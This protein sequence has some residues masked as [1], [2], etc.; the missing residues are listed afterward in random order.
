[1][2]QLRC[3]RC[4]GSM[5]VEVSTIP[6]MG[7]LGAQYVELVCRQCGERTSRLLPEQQARLQ[8]PAAEGATATAARPR[9]G[10]PPK[11][12]LVSVGGAK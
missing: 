10:R 6:E 11:R 2:T 9:R 5:Y 1:M 3:L 7:Y 4:H 12:A 8:E